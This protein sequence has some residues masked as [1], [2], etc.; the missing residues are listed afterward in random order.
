MREGPK[1]EAEAVVAGA[2]TTSNAK[3][4][5]RRERERE[6]E[7]DE[8]KLLFRRIVPSLGVP[9]SPRRQVARAGEGRKVE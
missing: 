8:R 1:L 3:M 2:E 7:R 4:I 6:R 9:F 5:T